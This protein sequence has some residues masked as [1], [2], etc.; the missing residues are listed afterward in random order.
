M[1]EK[2]YELAK[3]DGAARKQRGSRT[4]RAIRAEITLNKILIRPM[5]A[6]RQKA[7]ADKP[8]PESERLGKIEREIEQAELPVLAA[9]SHRRAQAALC[10]IDDHDRCRDC[11]DDIDTE[12]DDFDPDDGF[13]SAEVGE[14]DHHDANQDDG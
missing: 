5:R 10:G 12:L 3:D 13:H 8:G 6:H 11:A 2:A 7:A 14:D 4:T 9:H 1:K